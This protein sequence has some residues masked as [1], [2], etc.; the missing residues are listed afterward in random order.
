MERT[1]EDCTKFADVRVRSKEERS[2]IAQLW[3]KG[4]RSTIAQVFKLN[5]NIDPVI[6]SSNSLRARFNIISSMRS[7]LLHKTATSTSQRRQERKNQLPFIYLE[8]IA[9]FA[10]IS[11][12]IIEQYSRPVHAFIPNRATK[13]N[14]QLKL[15]VKN[16][17]PKQP[18]EK[19]KELERYNDDAFGLVFLAGGFISKDVDFAGTFLS[20]SA[21][22]ATSTYGGIL[23]ADA[24]MPG[25][26]ALST[27]LISPIIASL[28]S[29]GGLD[30]MHAPVPIEI[31]LCTV[32]FLVSIF[33]WRRQ[34]R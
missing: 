28:R 13:Q 23:S 12:I 16:I 25:I 11:L 27:L 17:P 7:I 14:R 30:N 3:S 26:V 15:F 9:L 20:V 31:V 21:I 18:A 8:R 22:A 5:V 1:C 33:N 19:E 4:E 6:R 24:R 29:S 2:T 10:F 32:S 34:T